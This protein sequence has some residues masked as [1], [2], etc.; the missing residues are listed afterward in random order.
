MRTNQYAY[1]TGT[2]LVHWGCR[3]EV[4]STGWFEQLKCIISSSEARPLKSRFW[5]G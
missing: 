5:Q 2:I 3:N 1:R 4:A